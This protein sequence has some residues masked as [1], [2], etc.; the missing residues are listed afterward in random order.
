MLIASLFFGWANERHP[1][2]DTV[3]YAPGGYRNV[4]LSLPSS[5]IGGAYRDI[6]RLPLSGL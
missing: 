5:D 6:A 3:Y 1:V 2:S 4:D